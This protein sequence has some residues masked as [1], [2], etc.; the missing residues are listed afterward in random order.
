[1]IY[2]EALIRTDQKKGKNVRTL[3][4]IGSCDSCRKARKWLDENSIDYLYHDIR[5][6]GLAIQMLERWS[7]R[8][9]WKK[10]LNTRSLTWRKIPET[11]RGDLVKDKALALMLQHPTLVKRPVL[12]CDEF[13]ALGFSPENYDK[14]LKQ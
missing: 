2:S 13:I 6:D 9:D 1:M 5:I 7:S 3:Y 12:E 11:D 14:I 10:L 4:G 8:I